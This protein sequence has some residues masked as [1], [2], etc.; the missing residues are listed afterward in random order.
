MVIPISSPS[1]IYGDNMLVV[2]NTSR[3]ESVIGRKENEGCYHAVCES[4][5]VGE[6]L[7]GHIPSKENVTDLMMN[8]LYGQS[9]RYFVSNILHCIHY[10]HQL[11]VL[12]EIRMQ[13]SKF[14]LIGTSINHERTINMHQLINPDI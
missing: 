8:V 9:R 2:Y 12:A 11:S 3:Q 14:N 4:V 7:V 6:S 13:P 10:N 5:A 1:Y